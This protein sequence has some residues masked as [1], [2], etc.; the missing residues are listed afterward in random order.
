M[1]SLEGL[2]YNFRSK[3]W[4]LMFGRK[5]ASSPSTGSATAKKDANAPHLTPLEKHLLD[6]G[7]VRDDGSDKFFGMA[8]VRTPTPNTLVGPMTD[9]S[10]PWMFSTETHGKLISLICWGVRR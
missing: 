5:Q 3:L 2:L 7:P 8:N 1:L 10:I 9:M 4:P 6:A